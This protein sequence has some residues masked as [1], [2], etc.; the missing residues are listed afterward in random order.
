MWHF[1]RNEIPLDIIAGRP[2]PSLWPIPQAVWSSDTC[3]IESDFYE[4]T[5][6]LD[7]T[8]CGDWADGTY[9]NSG[10]AGTCAEAV[11]N[12]ENFVYAKWKINYIAVY[13]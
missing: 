10:C 4:H 2:D 6:T 3:D 13:Q 8:L 12:P 1:A 11:A 5:L 7:T 9:A